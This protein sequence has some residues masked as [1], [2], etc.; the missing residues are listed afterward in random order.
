MVHRG[1][2]RIRVPAALAMTGL[3]LVAM[4]AS[5]T[6][7]HAATPAYTKTTMTFPVT[8]GPNND[9]K[10]SILGDLYVPT[11]ASAAAPVPAIL[12]TNGFGGSKDDQAGLGAYG[13]S[14]GYEVLSYSGLG[15]GGSGCNIEL[16]D[17]DWD[18]KAASQLI[19]FL[20]QRPEVK[21][22][23]PGD[24]RVGMIGG[25]YGGGVQFSTASI[26]PRLDTI[27][28]IITW[29]DLSYSLTPNNDSSTFTYASSP[30][31]VPKIDW[32]ELFFADGASAPLQHLSSTPK[33]TSTCPGFDPRVCP[34]NL[35]SGALSYPEASTIAFL[36]HAS[37]AN[38]MA[39]LRIPTML[40]QG[41]A[42]TLFNI[43]DATANY[44][45][46]KANGVPV[47]LVL[48][49]WGH[50]NSTPAP[51]EFSDS[52]PPSS[53][54]G[55]LILN[56][57]DHYLKGTG[58]STGPEVEYFR[59]WVPYPATG[60]AAPAYGQ[61]PSW[62][63]GSPQHLYLSGTNA[64]VGTPSAV[65]AGAAP[66][67]N[68][69]SGNPASYS[70]TSAVQTMQ[71]FASIPPTDPPGEVA[72]WSTPPLAADTD[73]VG[74][75]TLDATITAAAPVG[76]DPAADPVLFAK[77]YDIAPGGNVTLVQRLVSPIR[78]GAPGTVHI[79]LPGI[80]H[81]YAQGH[82][83]QLALASTDAAYVSSRVA[84]VVTIA[85]SSSHPGVLT[86]PVVVS[87]AA[88]APASPAGPPAGAVSPA[89][90]GTLPATGA[91]R[92]VA[93]AG[94]ALLA[95]ALMATRLRRRSTA[96]R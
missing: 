88:A 27:V 36:R 85:T 9:Q 50:S 34:A 17:P 22:D 21:K 77:L 37:A 28:P 64:L 35:T 89:P 80:V 47:K 57:F 62:P 86:L 66:V 44:R 33:P 65:Q 39:K 38:F 56:W 10:C 7:G 26:D 78:I 83:I 74:T 41:E 68:P 2:A 82:Q 20:G 53:Y 8:V 31:G 51:G 25:S 48:Q 59:D 60:T 15:F 23:H 93:I 11:T 81:R 6:A 72:T 40:M 55:Q 12:T 5:P 18:G 92:G 45:G 75:P 19:T 90:A 84:N 73:V 71:P 95:A 58:V 46:I 4:A 79:N 70:E 24:P 43:N 52:D 42:D 61:A 16:D 13:A 63:V 94:F 3:S 96:H 32:T 1:N 91:N 87:A 14:H 49:S 54:E 29:N 69:P 67:I 30:P 76:A